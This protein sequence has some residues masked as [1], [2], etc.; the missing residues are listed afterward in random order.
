MGTVVLS[1][2]DVV[3]P[4]SNSIVP[5]RLSAGLAVDDE[6]VLVS[7]SIKVQCSTTRW[8]S[9]SGYLVVEFRLREA[10]TFSPAT[11]IEIHPIAIGHFSPLSVVFWKIRPSQVHAVQAASMRGTRT[12]SK[13][14]DSSVEVIVAERVRHAI[15]VAPRLQ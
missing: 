4:K 6:D 10:L 14:V 7:V 11:H 12:K 13:E 9:R 2:I 8:P 5:S 1:E 15:R 3:A